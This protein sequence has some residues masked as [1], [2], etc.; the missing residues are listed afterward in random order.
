M[1]TGSWP[2]G[3]C[4]SFH[5]LLG[6]KSETKHSQNVQ[7][8]NQTEHNQSSPTRCIDPPAVPGDVPHMALTSRKRFNCIEVVMFGAMI[9]VMERS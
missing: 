8:P 6:S 1:C 3:D 9:F 5:S 4:I 7:N 2:E